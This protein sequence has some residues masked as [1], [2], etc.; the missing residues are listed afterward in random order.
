MRAS[1]ETSWTIFTGPLKDNKGADKV[2]EGVAMTGDELR[3]M[4]WFVAGVDGE[5]PT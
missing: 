3:G 5:I 4:T 1:N 2:A